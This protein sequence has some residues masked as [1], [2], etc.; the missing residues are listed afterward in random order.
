[1]LVT[2]QHW[3]PLGPD[4]PPLGHQHMTPDEI[5]N[6]S[7]KYDV[8]IREPYVE[9]RKKREPPRK[10]PTEPLPLRIALDVQGKQFRQR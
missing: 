4:A 5:V 9:P 2:I 10:P 3:V 7:T 1:M 6:L 8:M